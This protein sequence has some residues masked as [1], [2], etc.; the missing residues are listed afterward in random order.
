M[1][2]LS[3]LFLSLTAI[4]AENSDDL[5]SVV[6]QQQQLPEGDAQPRDDL[7]PIVLCDAVPDLI[8]SV[9]SAILI[10]PLISSSLISSDKVS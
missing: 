4:E 7:D 5:D 10:T 9:S 1:E 8:T 2:Q 3:N 6:S